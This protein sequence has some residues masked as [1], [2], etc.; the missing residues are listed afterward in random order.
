MRRSAAKFLA[1]VLLVSMVGCQEPQKED[2]V[3]EPAAQTAMMEPDLYATDPAATVADSGGDSY[4]AFPATTAEEPAAGATSGAVH[5]VA[6]GDTLY[7]LA[8]QYYNDQGRWKDIYEAN[9]GVISN[10][11]RIFI[12]Q[13]LVIP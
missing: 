9:R 12:G 8:R 1:A 5:L 2:D 6:K 4:T 10:P 11:D 7:R 13:E 3:Q